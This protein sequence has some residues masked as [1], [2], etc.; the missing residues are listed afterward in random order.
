MRANDPLSDADKAV[1]RFACSTFILKKRAMETSKSLAGIPVPMDNDRNNS[2][3]VETSSSFQ[4]QPVRAIQDITRRCQSTLVEKNGFATPVAPHRT[5]LL[6]LQ[7]TLLDIA[8]KLLSSS[9]LHD[10]DIAK[11]LRLAFTR[12]DNGLIPTTVCENVLLFWCDVLQLGLKGDFNYTMM[13]SKNWRRV[14]ECVDALLLNYTI[15]HR[16]NASAQYQVASVI[17][18]LSEACL[19][20]KSIGKVV[21]EWTMEV[22]MHLTLH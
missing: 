21:L 7:N 9:S 10:F 14:V 8:A 22:A 1:L 18:R 3:V 19:D 12:T 20:N 6:T 11:V 5:D 16:K 13:W 2:G 4:D 15:A 17:N